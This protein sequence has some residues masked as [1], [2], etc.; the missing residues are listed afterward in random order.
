ME[1]LDQKL[2]IDAIVYYVE[3]ALM[4]RAQLGYTSTTC[5]EF[6]NC[7]GA[8]AKCAVQMLVLIQEGL[9]KEERQELYTI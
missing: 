5:T 8:N 4:Q 2:G 1:L 3:R 7:H 9:A 6:T